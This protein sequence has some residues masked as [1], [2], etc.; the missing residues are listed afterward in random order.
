[1]NS[2]YKARVKHCKKNT[3]IGKILKTKTRILRKKTKIS[4]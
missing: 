1:M 2:A 4:I 3:K